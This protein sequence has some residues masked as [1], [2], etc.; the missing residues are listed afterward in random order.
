MTLTADDTPVRTQSRPTRV[1]RSA[2]PDRLASALPAA[3]PRS[4]RRAADIAAAL[5]GIGLGFVLAS[6]LITRP[7][8]L[9]TGAGAWS[10]EIGRV[11]GLLGTYAALLVLLLVARLPWLEREV[12]QDRLVRWHRRL[13][14][15]SLW[16]IASHVIAILLGYGAAEGRSIAGELWSLTTTVQWMLPAVAA[17]GL[18]VMVGVTS[19]RHARRRMAYETWWITHLYAYLAIAL[20][21]AHQV[22]LGQPF[23]E[24]RWLLIGWTVLYAATLGALIVF[25]WLVPS[26][27]GVR[28]DLR[29]TRVVRESADTISVYVSGRRLDRLPARGGQFFQWRFW[30]RPMWWQTHPYSLSAAPNGRGL[31]ITVKDLGDGSRALAAIRPGTRVWA[32]GPYGAFTPVVRSGDRVVLI[33]G[34]VGITPVRAVLEDLLTELPETGRVDVLYRVSR[35]QDVVLARELDALARRPQVRVRYLVGHRREHPMDAAALQ[36][37]VPDIR[38]ADVFVCGPQPLVEAVRTATGVLGMPPSRVHTEDF[39]F[40]P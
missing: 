8:G 35:P 18:M 12:G 21:Y 40:L 29:V 20:A 23:F 13:G 26:Y 5:A 34:G 28:H 25:R 3:R 9:P 1:N 31:R 14:P 39:Q 19:Y 6:W 2:S 4:R 10:T 24:H 37:L 30:T 38:G 15:W 16:L 33:G 7:A 22:T 32:E 27:R 17:F 11:T 36:R